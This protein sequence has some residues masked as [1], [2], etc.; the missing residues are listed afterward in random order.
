MKKV[1]CVADRQIYSL[2]GSL[3][4]FENGL[5][6]QELMPLQARELRAT[7]QALSQNPGNHEVGGTFSDR[8]PCKGA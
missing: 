8:Q 6:G 2:C 1:G 4:V 5:R 3:V 7:S